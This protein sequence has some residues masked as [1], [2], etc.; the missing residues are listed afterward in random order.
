MQEKV[1]E[2]WETEAVKAF[3]LVDWQADDCRGCYFCFLCQGRLKSGQ[4]TSGR[5][6][7]FQIQKSYE[8]CVILIRMIECQLPGK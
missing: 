7:E 5:V 8:L 4:A 1:S 6:R 2:I 3:Q